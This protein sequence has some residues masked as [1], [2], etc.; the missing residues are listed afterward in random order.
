MQNCNEIINYLFVGDKYSLEDHYD[1]E[2]LVNCTP[3]IPFPLSH[4]K[5]IRIPI[6]DTSSEDVKLFNLIQDDH[7]LEEMHEYITGG[8]N[9]LVNCNL[10]MQRSCSIA[11]CYLIKYHKYTPYKAV[12]YIQYKRPQA[13]NESVNFANTLDMI[14]KKNR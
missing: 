6:R 3:S 2:L 13:F 8:Q 14:Y 5:H 11:A 9:V 7:I 10:G 1:Y 4:N 12:K